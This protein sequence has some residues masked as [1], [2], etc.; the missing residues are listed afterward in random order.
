MQMLYDGT[1]DARHFEPYQGGIGASRDGRKILIT[2]F[3]DWL[4][5]PATFRGQE[6]KLKN[7]LFTLAGELSTRLKLFWKNDHLGKLR[8]RKRPLASEDSQ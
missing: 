1:L 2:T 7:H 4:Q 5:Q 3:N 6:A 8:H